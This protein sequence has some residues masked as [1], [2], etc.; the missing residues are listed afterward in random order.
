MVIVVREEHTLK[1]YQPMVFTEVGM[2]TE[3]REVQ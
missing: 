2:A 1:A 3:G